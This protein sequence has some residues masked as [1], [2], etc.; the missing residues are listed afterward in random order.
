MAARGAAFAL[1]LAVMLPGALAAP[2][3]AST[4]P[5][6]SGPA[7]Q[8]IVQGGFIDAS[9]D[10]AVTDD[11]LVGG[12]ASL[13]AVF[14]A[15]R[16]SKRLAGGGGW[17]VLGAT[18]AAGAT[19]LDPFFFMGP[20]VPHAFVTPALVADV[21]IPW[22][23]MVAWMPFDMAWRVSLGPAYFQSL[24]DAQ[25]GAFLLFNNE[26]ACFARPDLELVF[27]GNSA[28]TLRKRF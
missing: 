27:L 18:F 12:A 6:I 25:R 16:V 4:L 7:G 8:W 3:G 23:R 19:G 22:R 2:A 17:P 21:P 9:V 5:P 13:L 28:V 15:A 20:P 24:V 10:Y 14:G 26:L 1:L 11:V